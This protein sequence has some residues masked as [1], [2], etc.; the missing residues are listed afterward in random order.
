MTH[1]L[2]IQKIQMIAAQEQSERFFS[3][4]FVFDFEKSKYDIVLMKP[5][6]LHKLVIEQNVQQV[7]NRKANQNILLKFAEVQLLHTMNF[8]DGAAS[9]DS[10]LRAA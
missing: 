1:F 3:V 6:F 5:C 10:F 2:K 9:F 8:F 7:I 4:L